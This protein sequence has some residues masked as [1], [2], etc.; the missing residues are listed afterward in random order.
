MQSGDRLG[1]RLK[2]LLTPNEYASAKRTTFNA[3]YTSPVVTTAMYRAFDRLGVP[4]DAL[5]LE[6]GCGAGNFLAAAPRAMRFLG[7]EQD[8]IS[9]RL[10]RILYPDQDIRIEGFQ[11]NA[12]T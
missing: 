3:F 6:P 8:S 12:T 4:D 9:G 7:V 1:K 11:K 5:V 10:A 2:N